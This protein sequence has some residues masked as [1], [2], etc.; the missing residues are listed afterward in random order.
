MVGSTEGCP[1]VSGSRTSL[2]VLV[3]LRTDS[4]GVEAPAR[5]EPIFSSPVVMVIVTPAVLF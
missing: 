5:S 3:W 2:R 4:Q 1:K